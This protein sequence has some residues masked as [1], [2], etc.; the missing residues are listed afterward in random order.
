M[1]KVICVHSSRGGTGKTLIALNI[2]ATYASMGKSVALLDLDFRAPSLYTVFEAAR[3]QLV[4]EWTNDF[5]DCRASIEDVLVD[6]TDEY[7]LKGRLLVGFADP[8]IDA[9]R[10][11]SEKGKKWQMKALKKMLNLKRDLKDLDRVVLDTSP[12]VHYSSVNAVVS[13]DI[14][15]IV[16]TMDELDVAG[17]RR[18]LVELYDAFDKKTAIVLNKVTPYMLFS[19]DDRKRTLTRIEEM[20]KKPVVGIIPCYCDVLL[21]SRLKI[22]ALERP[23]HPFARTMHEVVNAL[24]RLLGA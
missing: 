17:A 4:T 22:F 3:R 23:E 18:M 10:Q 9:I 1:V 13:S 21:A 14:S 12:G 2:A 19:E 24:D 8:S 16:V 11:Y 20:F 5:L 15:V 6:V 7:D